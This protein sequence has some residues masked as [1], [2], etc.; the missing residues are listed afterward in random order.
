[1]SIVVAS[2][3]DPPKLIPPGLSSVKLARPAA[4][5]DVAALLQATLGAVSTEGRSQRDRL[6]MLE[7]ITSQ[8]L[9]EISLLRRPAR[10]EVSTQTMEGG[11]QAFELLQ[12]RVAILEQ[13]THGGAPHLHDPLPEGSV[14][15]SGL[16]G[17]V[18]NGESEEDE[19]RR[20]QEW[21]KW[22]D[23]QMHFLSDCQEGQPPPL[24]PPPQQQQHE[25]DRGQQEHQ[26]QQP[27][28]LPQQYGALSIGVSENE[29]SSAT[30]R[31]P[32]SSPHSTQDLASS[33]RQTPAAPMTT[34][35]ESRAARP[36]VR[37]QLPSMPPPPPT[38][39]ESSC[40]LANALTAPAR[41]RAAA[42]PPAGRRQSGLEGPESIMERLKRCEESQAH[43]SA[44]Q[45]L[46]SDPLR[47][48]IDGLRKAVMDLAD[49][50]DGLNATKTDYKVLQRWCADLAAEVSS[51]VSA[52]QDE[53]RDETR[54]VEA[55]LAQAQAQ[56]AFM[57]ESLSHKA[58]REELSRLQGAPPAAPVAAPGADERFKALRES[59]MQRIAEMMEL[60]ADKTE[61]RQL[62]EA[63][64]SHLKP[65]SATT[66]VAPLNDRISLMT[67][68]MGAVADART[69]ALYNEQR[70]SP[71][72]Q[73]ARAIHHVS[74]ASLASSPSA[75]HSRTPPRMQRP[76]SAGKLLNSATWPAVSSDDMLVAG[77]A[78][79][80]S[81]ASAA[82]LL[83]EQAMFQGSRLVR[84]LSASASAV[85]PFK[86]PKMTPD[87]QVT[88]S[89]GRLYRH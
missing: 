3:T 55:R 64:Y 44:W 72:P 48:E 29:E 8:L 11:P 33:P 10:Q 69:S 4:A 7:S 39:R 82:H 63:L 28:R 15:A 12:E 70:S 1:M 79:P 65:R 51:A 38:K 14:T 36:P 6:A 68:L 73:Q 81:S 58:D 31:A 13:L 2:A 22:K 61:L 76:A 16:G 49:G 5:D 84:P 80:S 20:H 21:Q 57:S 23:E 37:L 26:R 53:T 41:L 52:L 32:P 50:L 27:Q 86:T 47:A 43:L 56:I 67:P 71:Q 45:T 59:L 35:P 34:P 74:T 75:K 54:Q 88:G 85:S 9:E 46:L 62:E 17:A 87:R 30:L 77:A 25:E 83:P 19:L 60:K 89:D 78:S 24:P 40:L 18:P 42:P 66:T